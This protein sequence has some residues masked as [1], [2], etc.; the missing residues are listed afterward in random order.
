MSKERLS[1]TAEFKPNED[2]SHGSFPVRYD[3]RRRYRCL[4]CGGTFSTRI[5]TAYY[6][7]RCSRR[8]FDRVASMS[9]EGMGRTAIARVEGAGWNTA[10]RWL[11]KAP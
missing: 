3:R 8:T 10:N 4:A 11:A 9:V 5:D 7:F 1:S 2:H 6:R